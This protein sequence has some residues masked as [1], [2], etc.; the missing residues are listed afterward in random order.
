MATRLAREGLLLITPKGGQGRIQCYRQSI[1]MYI[2]YVFV[3]ERISYCFE[4]R[5]IIFDHKTTCAIS[6]ELPLA[7]HGRTVMPSLV[8]RE[9]SRERG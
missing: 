7:P 5:T 8:P 3:E 1:Y 4:Q 9:K 2:L 6:L